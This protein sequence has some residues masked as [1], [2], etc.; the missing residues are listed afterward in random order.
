MS[1]SRSGQA[2]SREDIFAQVTDHKQV[3]RQQNHAK[4]IQTTFSYRI[5]NI[6]RDLE[7]LQKT[8]E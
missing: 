4:S 7:N 8:I 6:K 5:E 2:K 1:K 3:S